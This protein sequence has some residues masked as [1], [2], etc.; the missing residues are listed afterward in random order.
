MGATAGC[1]VATRCGFAPPHLLH[2]A[3]PMQILRQ[4]LVGLV[5]KMSS[6]PLT[7]VGK[8]AWRLSF[9]AGHGAVPDCF[10]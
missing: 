7:S 9:H 8:T 10:G 3:G 2:A 4:R 6:L 1:A 5:C